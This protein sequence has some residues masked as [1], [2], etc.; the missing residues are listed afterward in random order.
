MEK[1]ALYRLYRPRKFADFCDQEVIKETIVNAIKNNKVSHA[2]LFSGP[3]GTG[4]TSLAK[5]VAKA[6]NCLNFNENDDICDHCENCLEA[7]N[8]I[9]IIEMDAA[10]N[11]GVD[12]IRDLKNRISIVPSKLKYKVYIID[13]VHMLTKEAFNALLKTLE[14]PPEYVIF[15]LATTEFYAVKETI[16]SRCQC[17]NFNR[18][19]IDNLKKQLKYI[20]DNEKIEIDDEVIQEI[21]EFSKGGFR[22]AIGLL[23]KLSSFKQGRITIDDY[24]KINGIISKKDIESTYEYILK[25]DFENVLNNISKIESSGYDFKVYVEGL[26]NYTREIIINHYTS[27]NK[28][29]IKLNIDLANKLNDLLTRLKDSLTPRIL[30]EV[31]ILEFMNNLFS[32]S[33]YFP[34]NKINV[35]ARESANLN[36]NISREIIDKKDSNGYEIDNDEKILRIHNAFAT[37]NK[38]LKSKLEEMHNNISNYFDNDIYGKVAKIVNNFTLSVCGDKTIIYTTS[39]A[40]L[41]KAYSNFSLVENLVKLLYNNDYK[42]VILL[43]EEFD[44][45]VE[46]YKTIRLD[47]DKMYKYI[48]SNSNLIKNESGIDSLSKYGNIEYMKKE[49]M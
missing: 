44:K 1:K 22:D 23:D 25:Q 39:K 27:D 46:I 18:I 10:S 38:D 5:I 3:R 15:I 20:A 26:L 36:T 24:S 13:E 19:S 34:G 31:N 8:S 47:K 49:D 43:K 21:A 4:K 9:D 17:F 16:V 41:A 29:D 12:Q 37:A 6:V 35:V 7:D 2:Y 14:E 45:E 32:S 40:N 48:E 30:V 42:I 28:C 33:N 11:N